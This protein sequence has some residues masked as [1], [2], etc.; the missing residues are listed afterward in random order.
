MDRL[1]SVFKAVF[2]KVANT[3]TTP[4]VRHHSFR[5]FLIFSV[6]LSFSKKP[7]TLKIVMLCFFFLI[8]M[9]KQPLNSQT[10]SVETHQ[11]EIAEFSKKEI[12][13]IDEMH[14]M[15]LDLNNAKK[16]AALLKKE[17]Q[18]LVQKIKENNKISKD[19]GIK[20]KKN[21]VLASRR[22][23][24]LYK[25]NQ[26]GQLNFMATAD[27]IYEFF[28][29]KVVLEIILE[30]DERILTALMDHKTKQ[31]QIL[32]NLQ[33]QKT[34][35]ADLESDLT[36]HIQS[37]SSQ[38]EKR[39]RLL[40]DIRNKKSLA[41]AAIESLRASANNLN[42]TL[43][44]FKKEFPGKKPYMNASHQ[45]FEDLKGLLI[46]PVTGKIIDLFGPYKNSK[47]KIV[48]F[49]SGINIKAERG[50]PVRAVYK[51]VTLFASWFKGYGNLIIIDHGNHYYTLYAHAEE[52]FIQKGAVVEAGEVIAT[53]GDTGSMIGP[54][55]H[56]EVR[57]HGKPINPLP[58]IDR[59]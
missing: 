52:L 39:A 32:K 48:N 2:K 9:G 4:C 27:T 29:R 40:K 56:F 44:G 47:F 16:K 8:G 31:R 58:W 38:R 14:Q 33:R 30:H 25:L 22:L 36:R 17:I 5:L 42:E 55:L 21:E 10:E 23:V 12:K 51:G 20:I 43:S 15:D 59:G 3:M 37:I 54:A 46:M 13:I 1:L 28:N 57:H 18:E 53:V 41:L 11:K 19:L 6:P 26:L 7:I 49:R 34:K 45:S 24:A 35:K 50:E